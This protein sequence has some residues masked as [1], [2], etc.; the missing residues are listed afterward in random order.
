MHVANA[1]LH[2]WF[3][4]DMLPTLGAMTGAAP[5][6]SN[7]NSSGPLPKFA[8]GTAQTSSNPTHFPAFSSSSTATAT[9]N[10][11]GAGKMF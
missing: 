1:V 2:K 3:G 6:D 9:G 5:M 8:F 10:E 11:Q 7:S 4:I